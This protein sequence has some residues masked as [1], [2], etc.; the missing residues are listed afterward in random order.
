MMGGVS[1]IGPFNIN[2]TQGIHLDNCNKK[3]ME[4][5]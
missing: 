5:L 2:Q 4:S 1:N 3:P